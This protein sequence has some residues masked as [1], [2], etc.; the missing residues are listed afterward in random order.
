MVA[1]TLSAQQT[2]ADAQSEVIVNG[3]TYHL[4][5]GKIITDIWFFEEDGKITTIAEGQPKSDMIDAAGKLI[6][7][8]GSW[9]YAKSL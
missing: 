6:S 2:P 5:N 1:T 4:G 3:G 8:L 9:P 7:I